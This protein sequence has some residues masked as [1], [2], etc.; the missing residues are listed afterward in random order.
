MRILKKLSKTLSVVAATF[1]IGSLFAGSAF[2]QTPS[3]NNNTRPGWGYGDKH[4]HHIGP[5][6]ISNRPDGDHDRDD[7]IS[8]GFFG[9]FFNFLHQ[10]RWG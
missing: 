8:S 1:V 4:H 10:H 3:H 6:G 9:W 7:L 2:A 5:P